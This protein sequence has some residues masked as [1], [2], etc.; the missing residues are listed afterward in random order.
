MLDLSPMTVLR[1]LRTGTIPAEQYCKGAPWVIKR[2]V[3]E[4]RQRIKRT[5]SG[6]KGPQSSTVAQQPSLFR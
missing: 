4:D 3:I 2:Q 5:K 6:R 1:R